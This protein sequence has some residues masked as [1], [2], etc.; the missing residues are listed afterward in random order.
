MP[1]PCP[2]VG[3]E[4]PLWDTVVEVKAGGAH[5]EQEQL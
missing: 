3:E 2:L 1:H 5:G 4:Y